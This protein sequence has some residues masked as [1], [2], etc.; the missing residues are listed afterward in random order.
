MRHY[1]TLDSGMKFP[2]Q[3]FALWKDAAGKWHQ[4]DTDNVDVAYKKA[5]LNDGETYEDTR[6][7]AKRRLYFYLLRKQLWN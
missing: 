4:F 1:P 3:Y 2:R 7:P 5:V 6:Y